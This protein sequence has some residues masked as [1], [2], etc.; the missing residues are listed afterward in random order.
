[1]SARLLPVVAVLAVAAAWGAGSAGTASCATGMHQVTVKGQPGF[2][3]CGT[4][5]ATVRLGGR[6]LRFSNGLC[7]QAAGAFTVNIGTLVPG[8]RTGKPPSFG[9]TTHTGK[10]GKQL[11]AA[12]GFAYGGRGY[13]V[14]DQLVTLAPGLKSGTFSGRILASSTRVTGSFR[15]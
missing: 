2:R 7:R 5:S 3:F 6:T 9:L 8:L 14:A 4:A 12:V 13:A 15:C 11:N 1:M 10:A